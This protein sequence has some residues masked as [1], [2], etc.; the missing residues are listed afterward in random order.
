MIRGTVTVPWTVIKR[1][2][3]MVIGLGPMEITKEA[4]QREDEDQERRW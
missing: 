4:K 1:S 3:N 2:I